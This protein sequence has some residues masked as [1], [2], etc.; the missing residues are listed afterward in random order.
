VFVFWVV[1]LGF[2]WG[3]CGFVGVFVVGFV[4]L[5][6]VVGVW[7][8][9]GVVWWWFCLCK[10]QPGCKRFNRLRGEDLGGNDDFL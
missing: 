2:V 10:L 9:W 7:G 4:V 1:V 3:C 8:G 6:C 5:L